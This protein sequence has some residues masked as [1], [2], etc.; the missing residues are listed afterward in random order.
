MA[1][2]LS[3]LWQAAIWLLRLFY[4]CFL[5]IWTLVKVLLL[6]LA[7][8]SFLQG[9]YEVLQD[10]Y[11]RLPIQ[12][13]VTVH[14]PWLAKLLFS[15][16]PYE[17][18]Q[19]KDLVSHRLPETQE[20]TGQ[21]SVRLE[22]LLPLRR[23]QQAFGAKKDFCV[24]FRISGK[25]GGCEE[26]FL[27]DVSELLSH[28]GV[29][30][31]VKE[32]TETSKD[33]LLLFCPIASRKGTDIENALEG[34]SDEQKVLLVVMDLIPKDNP[35]PFVDAQHRVPHPAVVRTMHTRFTL[36]DGFYP[37]EMNEAAVADV[38]AALKALAED[39]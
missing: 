9:P 21:V 26:K 37:C 28:Q 36:Q 12:T 13:W 25:T 16:E 5:G 39:Q 17:G 14:L 20:W 30:L 4:T 18:N 8:R 27:K 7:K 10:F 3:L 38:A 22:E 2:I 34:L 33:P 32:F 24:Q 23:I 35:G 6:W 11:T 15:Q 1:G 31:Q 29:S 19:R